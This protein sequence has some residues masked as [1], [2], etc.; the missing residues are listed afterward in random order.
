[1]AN[2]GDELPSPEWEI[3]P[4]GEVLKIAR[5][6][7]PNRIGSGLR[8]LGNTCFLNATLQCLAYTPSFYNYIMSRQHEQ[9]CRASQFCMLCE[10]CHLVLKMQSKKMYGTAVAPTKIVRNIRLLSR[11][12]RRGRQEDAHEFLRCLIQSFQ[13]NVLVA[14]KL[15]K[16]KDEKIKE[17]TMVYRMY[18]GYFRS[19]VK[20]TLCKYPS[21]TYDAFLDLSLEVDKANTVEKV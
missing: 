9:R 18:G 3:T 16:L 1:M 17:T 2:R 21:N 6:L 13:K 11:G 5:W 20:C 7:K 4:A 10:F 15:G 19:Q 14:L 12:F 8:N